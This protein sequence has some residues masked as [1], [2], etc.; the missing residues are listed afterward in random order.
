MA[1]RD[2]YEVLAVEKTAT[3]EEI[4]KAYRKAAVKYHPDKNPGDKFNVK[5]GINS[6]FGVPMFRL[7]SGVS[8]CPAEDGTVAREKIW[9][10]RCN[11]VIKWEKEI[12][13]KKNIKYKNNTGTD[14]VF[15]NGKN[16]N[17]SNNRKNVDNTSNQIVDNINILSNSIIK[18]YIEKGMSI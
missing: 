11:E 5:I 17:N 1:K 18:N 12:G 13:I 6:D 4:K 15:V 14:D 8:I 10:E 16:T 7:L 9:I 2:Y 3:I